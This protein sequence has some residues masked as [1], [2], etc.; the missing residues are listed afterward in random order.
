MGSVET[1]K[2]I[3]HSPDHGFCHRPGRALLAQWGLVGKMRMV[4]AGRQPTLQIL[5]FS[6]FC[7]AAPSFSLHAPLLTGWSRAGSG[8]GDEQEGRGRNEKGQEE[9]GRV[10]EGARWR[11]ERQGGT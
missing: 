2:A 1:K 4:K 11:Q 8:D 9:L 5:P 7:L 3:Q 10:E 6:I